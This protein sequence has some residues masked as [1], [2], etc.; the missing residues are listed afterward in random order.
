MTAATLAPSDV[1]RLLSVRRRL[2]VSGQA[3]LLRHWRSL[4]VL[5]PILVLV[6]LVR[7]IGMSTFP[8]YVDDPGTYLSQAWSLQYEGTLSPYSYFYDHAPAGWIQLA[9]WSTLTDGFDRYDS[10]IGFGNECM[11]LAGIISTAL[12]FALGR[13]LGL[14]RF[15]SSVAALLFGLS[16]LSVLYGRWTFLDNL[17]TPWLLA[18]FA[19]WRNR[20]RWLQLSRLLAPGF[21]RDATRKSRMRM[22]RNTLSAR[23]WVTVK[24]WIRRRGYSH[25]L[26]PARRG[27]SRAGA[28][29]RG[30]VAD[31]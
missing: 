28:R 25:E 13:R 17:V 24:P 20:S 3:W 9:L 19:M 12:V 26:A 1:R 14:T 30:A 23:R 8:R 5:G 18:A 31:L 6:G 21:R 11:L 16:P 22:S 29:A 10:A 15:G 2:A 4:A 7:G 27:F